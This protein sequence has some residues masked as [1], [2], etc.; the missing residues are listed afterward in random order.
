MIT[1]I[2][3]PRVILP[4]SRIVVSFIDFSIAGLL[5]VGMMI[6]YHF[7]H[8]HFTPSW[9]VVFIPLYLLMAFGSIMGVGLLFAALNV[10]YH[11]F[12]YIVPFVV[13][14]GLY[15]SPVGFTSAVATHNDPILRSVYSLNP[16]V[17]VIDGFRWSVFG[18]SAPL[19]WQGQL[20]ST[21][22]ILLFLLGGFRFFRKFERG[23]ADVI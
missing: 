22:V 10:R 11:D 3:F 5:L 6:V 20:I 8:Y 17:G 7:T 4:I 19:F 23:F 12:T 18:D 16:M 21:S 15:V 13:T 9:R 1:K 14:F 2:Y